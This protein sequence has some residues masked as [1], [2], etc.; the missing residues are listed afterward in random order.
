MFK[1]EYGNWDDSPKATIIRML[2]MTFIG[3]LL[4]PVLTLLGVVFIFLIWAIIEF[5]IIELT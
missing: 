5:I 3:L 1:D 2:L 4:S